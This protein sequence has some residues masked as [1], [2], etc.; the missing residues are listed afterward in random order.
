[1]QK[2]HLHSLIEKEGGFYSAV[3]LLAKCCLTRGDC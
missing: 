1:M 3:C 2:L